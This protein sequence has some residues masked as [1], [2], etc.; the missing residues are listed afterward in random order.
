MSDIENL[1]VMLGSCQRGNSEVL[2]RGSENEMDL[3]SNRREEDSNHNG[4]DY[5]SYLNTNISEK[6]GL[7]VETSR[8]ISSEISSQMSKRLEEMQSS[9]NSQILEVINTAIETRVL[10]SIKNVVGRQNSA[11]NTNLDLRS[12]RLH[13]DHADQENSQKDLRSNRLHPENAS[14]SIQNAQNEFPR[15]IP[16][17][18]SQTKHCRENSVDS[19]QSEDDYG[20][21]SNKKIGIKTVCK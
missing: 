5:R 9:L 15:L 6:G 14:K 16:V 18:S 12:N 21:D 11:E 8:A 10:P 7:T 3:E 13:Q 19:Q 20:Y 17:K 1:D 2:N 4:K